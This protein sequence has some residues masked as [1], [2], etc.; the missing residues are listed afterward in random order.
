M[1]FFSMSH[2]GSDENLILFKV[3]W[4]LFAGHCA[5]SAV[6]IGCS[7]LAAI[8]A[9]AT[10]AVFISF[11]VCCLFKGKCAREQVIY[12][13]YLYSYIKYIDFM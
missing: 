7:L 10:L 2:A 5:G 13:L 3:S 11:L 8:L 9:I 1:Y 12:A 6:I 4:I